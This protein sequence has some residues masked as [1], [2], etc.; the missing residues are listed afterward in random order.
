MYIYNCLE[1]DIMQSTTYSNG[2]VKTEIKEGTNILNNNLKVYYGTGE[3]RSDSESSVEAS[4]TVS[5]KG[6]VLIYQ[7][8]EGT[9]DTFIIPDT[10]KTN[11][12]V[13]RSIKY[14]Y[15]ENNAGEKTLVH[16][17]DKTKSSSVVTID[18]A[19]IDSITRFMGF[20][21]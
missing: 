1:T 8:D 13:G 15:K 10:I 17:E 2:A 3:L 21:R 12:L 5:R 9:N 6:E 4:G 16:I 19:D 14:Y 11:G 20:R 7:Y 18:P